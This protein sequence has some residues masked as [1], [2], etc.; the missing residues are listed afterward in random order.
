MTLNHFGNWGA[1][2]TWI[3]I[4][5]SFFIFLPYHKKSRTK[6]NKMYLAFIVASAFEMYGIPLSLY[7]IAWAFGI[8]APVGVF[9]GHTLTIILGKE[10][11]PIGYILNFIGGVLILLGWKEIFTK[12]WR[13]SEDKRQLVTGG[14]YIFSRHP[15]YL[16]FILMTLGLLVHWATLPLLVMW[17]ILVY[18][19]YTLARREEK[20]MLDEFGESY[21]EYMSKTA[22]FFG[23]PTGT[24]RY[25]E[26]SH[27]TERA[28]FMTR[29]IVSAI[30]LLIIYMVVLSIGHSLT[31]ATLE[32]L[33]W[34]PLLIIQLTGLG[35][36]TSMYLFMRD[37]QS[38][39]HSIRSASS[40]TVSGG[41]S[42][43]TMVACCLHHVTDILP[44]IGFSAITLLL[45]SYQYVFMSI[46]ALS[47]IIG[48][49][50]VL[51]QMMMYND[52][53]VG[54]KYFRILSSFDL[55]KVR[56][57][58][59]ITSIVIAAI[60]SASA[61]G[62]APLSK[63]KTKL[64]EVSD[65]QNSIT[66][67]FRQI[68]SETALVFHTRIDTHPVSLS[69]DLVEAVFLITQG[70]VIAPI[71]WEGSPPGGHHRIGILSFPITELDE[72]SRFLI[73]NVNGMFEWVTSTTQSISL[74]T[75]T[76]VF[77]TSIAAIFLILRSKNPVTQL[78]SFD[79][80][81]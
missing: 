27:I 79:I 23:F 49:V 53:L 29:A 66:F 72:E 12:Y 15:Q 68:E 60:L 7:F 2:I 17:P 16:G 39:S 71:K 21:K 80:R 9:W 3:V 59:L 73:T 11:M 64:I 46:G 5:G 28:R 13:K 30:S 33:K 75:I 34:W 74:V 40:L 14:I 70:Q 69:F 42:S 31:H 54:H 8:K 78:K 10:S 19:Y 58:T 26:D 45:S 37:R 57:I 25:S 38:L 48:F 77:V 18:R 50:I 55:K 20:E 6:H 43:S 41:I 62:V 81:D 76:S 35:L 61:L 24:L 4:F 51:K 1:V 52:S 63:E 22:M 47:N 67:T 65:T 44:I 56:N 32:I 36:Q